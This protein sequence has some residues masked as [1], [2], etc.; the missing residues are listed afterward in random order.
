MERFRKAFGDDGLETV[1]SWASPIAGE[2]WDRHYLC[3]ISMWM[4]AVQFT[5]DEALLRRID[6]DR[7][8]KELGRSAFL[9][10]AVEHYLRQKRAG[11]IRNAYRRGYGSKPPSENEFAVDP[12]ALAWPEE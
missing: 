5:I 12:E 4:R 7:E 9:R 1:G 2:A 3:G 11:E 10:R 6:A 8:A